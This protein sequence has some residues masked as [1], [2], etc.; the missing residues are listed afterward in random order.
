MG[1]EVTSEDVRAVTRRL[2]VEYPSNWS[3]RP[4]EQVVDAAW[5][6]LREKQRAAESD[7]Q[8]AGLVVSILKALKAGRQINL[9]LTHT[10]ECKVAVVKNG[11]LHTKMLPVGSGSE[12]FGELV[13][14][15]IDA[16]SAKVRQ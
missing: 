7:T 10:G 5:Q 13:G 16:L 9:V 11:D 1:V 14:E 12:A 15:T 6:V 4:V 3:L 8:A 2:G